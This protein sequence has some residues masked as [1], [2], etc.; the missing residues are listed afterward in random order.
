MTLFNRSLN[1]LFDVLFLPFRGLDPLWGLAAVSL[2]AG[3]VLLWIFG[4]A[5]DQTRIREVRDRIRGNLLGIRL[6]GD[7]LGLLA[8]L[9]ARIFRQTLTYLRHAMPPMLVMLAP[10]LLILVQLNLRFAVR[11]LEPGES[12][13]LTL[14]LRQASP[15]AQDVELG[16]PPEVT[17]ETPGVRIPSLGEVSWRLRVERPG[18]HT[19]TVRYGGD[20]VEKLLVAGGSWAAV[21]TLRTAGFVDGLLYPGEP[22]IDRASAIASVEVR[23]PPL[24]LALFGVGVDWLLFFFVASLAS[25]FAFR[26]AL[27][28][29]I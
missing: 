6:F 29:E 9:Q 24:P 25:G 13:V 21:S 28:V 17:V 11:P 2:V 1:G 5:S 27:G 23:Y 15:L 16:V 3:I 20:T 18:R 22:P 12:T 10:V 26:R 4:K 8:R 7:D 19:V 14:R